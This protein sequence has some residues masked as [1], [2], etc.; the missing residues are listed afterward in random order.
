MMNSTGLLT[1]AETAGQR[2][3]TAHVEIEHMM[4]VLRRLELTYRAR[5]AE[6]IQVARRGQHESQYSAKPCSQQGLAACR[7]LQPAGACSLQGPPLWPAWLMRKIIRMCAQAGAVPGNLAHM[8]RRHFL[9]ASVAF[10]TSFAKEPASTP[11][12]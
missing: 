4:A 2:D 11:M 1:P 7:G 3:G 12:D 6:D 8:N 9:Y 10:S 5:D